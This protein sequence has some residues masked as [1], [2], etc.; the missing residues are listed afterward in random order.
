MEAPLWIDKYKPEIEDFPQEDVKSSLKTVSET[1]MNLVIGGPA[2]VGKTVAASSVSRR[3]HDRPDNNVDHINVSDLFNRSK[4]DLMNEDRFQDLGLSRSNYSKRDLINRVIKEIAGYKTVSG[5]FKTI[6]LD[7]AEDAREDFQNSLRR[8]IERHSDSTQFV[9]TTRNPS[10]LIDPIQSRCYSIQVVPPTIDQIQNITSRILDNEGLD[11]DEE[12]CNY[13][14][15]R[16]SPNVRKYLLHL[17]TVSVQ[18]DEI[19]TENALDLYGKISNKDKLEEILNE[20]K[21]ENYRSVKDGISDLLDEE[22]YTGDK[23]MDMI[24]ETAVDNLPESEVIKLCSIMGETSL[25]TT[26]SIDPK[27]QIVLSLGRWNESVS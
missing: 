10:G 16:E 8:T 18:Y 13:I 17:Q 23:I 24:V 26:K 3:V 6:I 9:F 14:W 7:N 4:K 15:S 2:G 27:T 12:V 20:T 25:D 22:G 19:S 5:G 21:N 11:V 1:S